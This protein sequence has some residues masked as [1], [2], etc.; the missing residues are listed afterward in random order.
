VASSWFLFFSYHNV[1]RSNKHQII[2]LIRC[3]TQTSRP[4]GLK[5]LPT[6][7]E[8]LQICPH[9]RTAT[10]CTWPVLSITLPCSRHRCSRLIVDPITERKYCALTFFA[11]S[12]FF[13]RESIKLLF[14]LTTI[15]AVCPLGSDAKWS[16]SYWL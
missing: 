9:C 1:A 7:F 14:K 13:H 3:A 5:Y 2:Q 8:L 4:I 10:G 15:E 11:S 6:D 12:I 16:G